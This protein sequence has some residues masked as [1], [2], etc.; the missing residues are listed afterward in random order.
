MAQIDTLKKYLQ[1]DDDTMDDPLQIILDMAEKDYIN[2]T[3]QSEADDKIV[4]DMA[5]ERYQQFGNEGL[6]SISYSGINEVFS[7]DYS[8]RVAKLIRSKTKMVTL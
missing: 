7:S 5:I 4:L 3:H 8:D 6:T 1:I 2:R